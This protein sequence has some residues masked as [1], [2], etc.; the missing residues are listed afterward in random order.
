MKI[1]FHK[2]ILL[3]VGLFVLSSFCHSQSE[4]EQFDKEMEELQ[5]LMDPE[6]GMFSGILNSPT[7]KKNDQV[8][9][10]DRKIESI[11]SEHN[12]S[13][14]L[15]TVL[16]LQSV[17]WVPIGDK[18]IDKLMTTYYEKKTSNLVDLINQ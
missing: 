13:K 5:K 12:D 14:K 10:L 7:F 16:K 17:S 8:R 2:K 3:L 18:E 4:Y 9:Y 6:K 1:F 15:V 11:I